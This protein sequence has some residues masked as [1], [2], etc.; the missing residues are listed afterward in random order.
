MNNAEYFRCPRCNEVIFTYIPSQLR[1]IPAWSTVS[2]A[3]LNRYSAIFR[4]GIE[5]GDAI[6]C[7]RCGRNYYNEIR[8]LWKF[9]RIP[10][11]TIGEWDKDEN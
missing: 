2:V 10:V 11:T 3:S 8:D 9:L 4:H 7:H 6:E 5:E 1:N